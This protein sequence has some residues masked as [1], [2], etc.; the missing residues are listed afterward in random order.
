M[1]DTKNNDTKNVTLQTA[2]ATALLL[3]AGYAVQTLAARDPAGCCGVSHC[4]ILHTPLI[5]CDL[6]DHQCSPW[7]PEYGTCC[8]VGGCPTC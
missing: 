3:N 8:D 5:G 2:I 7:A 4:E 1:N 6:S